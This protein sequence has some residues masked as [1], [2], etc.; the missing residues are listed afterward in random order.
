MLQMQGK[1]IEDVRKLRTLARHLGTDGWVADA[2]YFIS[3]SSGYSWEDIP[4]LVIGRSV[5]DNWL[6][7]HKIQGM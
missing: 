5:Y 6:V 4:E 1:R 2:E 7:L 3:T